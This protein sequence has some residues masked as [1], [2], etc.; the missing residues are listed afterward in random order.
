MDE[1][2]EVL[3][4]GW[5]RPWVAGEGRRA[6]IAAFLRADRLDGAAGR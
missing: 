3:A 6:R 4:R 5:L 1:T 2:L